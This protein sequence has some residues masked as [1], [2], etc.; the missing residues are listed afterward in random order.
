MKDFKFPVKEAARQFSMDAIKK[1]FPNVMGDLVKHTFAMNA[2]V[3]GYFEGAEWAESRG[4]LDEET[5]EGEAELKVLRY[6]TRVPAHGS[7]ETLINT[8]Y[9]LGFVNGGK[10]WTLSRAE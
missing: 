3:H 2:L 9:K 6:M 10:H 8:G 1:A 5:I 7:D 4:T